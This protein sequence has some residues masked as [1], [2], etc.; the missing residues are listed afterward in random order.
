MDEGTYPGTRRVYLSPH[1]RGDGP[2]AGWFGARPR[3]AQEIPTPERTAPLTVEP[4][5]DARHWHLRGRP[6]RIRRRDRL[7]GLIHEIRARGLRCGLSFRTLRGPSR[8]EPNQTH[9][10]DRRF[11][12]QLT[13][14]TPV[15]VK[16]LTGLPPE[17]TCLDDTG[18]EGRRGAL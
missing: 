3:G 15:P 8:P 11:G 2:L 5:S 17:K 7:G 4:T 9:R 1:A 13:G 10:A 6:G 16:S 14:A 12:R 18:E